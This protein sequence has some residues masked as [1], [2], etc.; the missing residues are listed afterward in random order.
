VSI[1]VS[2][3]AISKTENFSAVLAVFMEHRDFAPLDRV[4]LNWIAHSSVG[5]DKI[6]FLPEYCLQ[7]M[8]NLN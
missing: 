4:L 7:G 1:D 5:T 2:Q 6:T 3:L 8:K